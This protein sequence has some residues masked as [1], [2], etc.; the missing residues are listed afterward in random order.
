MRTIN[1]QPKY[2]S[3]HKQNYFD[4]ITSKNKIEKSFFFLF[5]TEIIIW[6]MLR[7][8]RLAIRLFENY[9][10]EIIKHGLGDIFKLW[11]WNCRGCRNSALCW[12]MTIEGLIRN[13]SQ[14]TLSHHTRWGDPKPKQ[15]AYWIWVEFC[16]EHIIRY[17]CGLLFC[18][19][20]VDN[21]H[22]MPADGWNGWGE[23]WVAF[24]W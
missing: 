7:L 19:N 4:A 10:S 5:K 6:A 16:V 23:H 11:R 14:L 24:R 13:M 20:N 1:W 3:Q 15:R 21:T 2:I 12:L 17:L 22:L 8:G 18:S 9:E